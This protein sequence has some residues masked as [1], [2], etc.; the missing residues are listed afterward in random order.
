VSARL[1][2]GIRRAYLEAMGIPVWVRRDAASAVAASAAAH[3]RDVDLG[4]IA[5]RVSRC[6][7]CPLH[8]GRMRTVFGVGQVGAR[9]MVIGEAPGAEEDR[10]GEPFVG[11][12]GR[13]L[14][15]MLS[16]C[17]LGREAVYITNIVKCRPPGN[18]DPRPEEVAACADYLRHQL[19]L[20]R[21]E[22]ILA[23]GRVAAQNLLGSDSPIGRL[24]GRDHVHGETGVPVIVTYHPA[25]LLRRPVEKRKSWADLRRM[26]SLLALAPSASQ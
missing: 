20:V 22:V 11:R 9:C 5:E 24:R 23:V 25:Y 21:P 7:A 4:A 10:Q 3:G 2:E 8:G 13:L 16:A 19:A 15:A 26:R 18:R 1:D 12:A 17:G 6:T 14:D